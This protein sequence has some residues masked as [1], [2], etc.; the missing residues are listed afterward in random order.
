MD[1]GQRRLRPS[2]RIRACYVRS[3]SPLRHTSSQRVAPRRASTR[4]WA[5]QRWPPTLR[6]TSRRRWSSRRRATRPSRP[7]TTSRPWCTT[8]RC[9][10]HALALTTRQTRHSFPCARGRA[11][12]LAAPPHE[13]PAARCSMRA[14]GSSAG[15]SPPQTAWPPH[16]AA[17]THGCACVLRGADLHVRARLLR[18]EQRGRRA[19][20]ARPDHQAGEPRD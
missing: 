2:I 10:P 19:V 18:G 11:S 16:A 6:R 7:P 4:A 13:Q 12:T 1:F 17:H 20:D 3:L 14:T 5:A 15:S 8:T 9:A